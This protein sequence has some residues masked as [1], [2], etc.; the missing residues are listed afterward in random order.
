MPDESNCEIGRR[1]GAVPLTV[2]IADDHPLMVAGVRRVLERDDQIEVVGEAHSGPEL[3]AMVDRRRPAVVVMDLRMPGMSGPTCIQRLRSAWPQ[4][5]IIVLSAC[6]DRATIDG[7]LSAGA[8]SYVVKSVESGDVA[9]L[10]RHAANDDVYHAGPRVRDL[11]APLD[12]PSSPD[13]TSREHTIL[14]AVAAGMTTAAISQ[15]LWVSE[16]TVKFH[17]TNIYRKLGVPNRAAAIRYAFD[18]Q[19]VAA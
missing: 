7:A 4:L 18:H 9:A 17:L 15:E 5:K 14:A 12:Q 16:H 1:D 11:D 13:L 10:V 8:S 2:V 3:I 6:E 19:L